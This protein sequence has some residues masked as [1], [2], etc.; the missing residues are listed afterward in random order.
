MNRGGLRVD[1][2]P[3][4]ADTGAKF[5]DCVAHHATTEGGFTADDDR[6]MH[7][8]VAGWAASVGIPSRRL[9]FRAGSL[10]GAIPPRT[11]FSAS[12]G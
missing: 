11:G 4:A 5:G 3:V 8:G 2:S 12:R 1:V 9:G 10:A 7:R 6:G